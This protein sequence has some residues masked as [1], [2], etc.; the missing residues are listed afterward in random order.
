M[1]PIIDIEVNDDYDEEAQIA[2]EIHR[3]KSNLSMDMAGSIKGNGS[4]KSASEEGE[5]ENHLIGQDTRFGRGGRKKLRDRMMIRAY[6]PD[7]AQL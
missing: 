4:F 6:L 1:Q 3:L 7:D 2:N 5:R